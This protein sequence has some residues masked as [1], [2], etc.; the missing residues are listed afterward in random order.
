M[1]STALAPHH[2]SSALSLSSSL[3]P[4]LRKL[5]SGHSR[6][7]EAGYLDD[8]LWA[9]PPAIRPELRPPILAAL[10]AAKASLRPAS[11]A[12]L[13]QWVG[14]LALSV[15]PGKGGSDDVTARV[16][17]LVSLLHGSVPANVL[18]EDSLRT[19]SR[20]LKFMPGYAELAP[21]MDALS[22]ETRTLIGR[23]ERLAVLPDEAAPAPRYDE[24]PAEAKARV[25]KALAALPALPER[26]QGYGGGA[27]DQDAPKSLSTA[28][29][30]V[31]TQ[32]AAFR[33]PDDNDP[34]VQA[35]LRKMGV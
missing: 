29:R 6:F 17:V 18:T 9:P 13:T 35:Y 24:L 5:L 20:K 2:P 19:V 7:S 3:P 31:A 26:R 12:N 28:L 10:A 4:A 11:K 16:Q 15:A 30:G 22:A 23:L 34:A 27:D 8:G 1:A 14:T 33:L 21:A 25:D 32:T